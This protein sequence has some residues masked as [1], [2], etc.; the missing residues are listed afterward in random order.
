MKTQ[1]AVAWKA[2]APLTIEFAN[3]DETRE[4]PQSVCVTQDLAGCYAK[5]DG[6][7]YAQERLDVARETLE[8]TIAQ[9]A[10]ATVTLNRPQRL[11]AAP[12]QMFAEL[13]AALK[14]LPGLGARALLITGEGRAF[15]S[16]AD[17][18]GRGGL[19]LEDCSIGQPA[20]ASHRVSG[21]SPHI[22][23]PEG[24]ARLWAV[25]EALLAPA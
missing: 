7:G 22:A 12:P 20:P 24:A 5:L 13:H 10:V 11:N 16:G 21:F 17:L 18:A 4:C 8:W 9:G 14:L 6:P 2:G 15:C 25:S 3:R 23:D 19:Y 1:A